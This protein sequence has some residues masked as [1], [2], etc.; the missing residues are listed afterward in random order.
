MPYG[1]I[2]AKPLGH[3]EEPVIEPCY[4]RLKPTEE[5]YV[6]PHHARANF[7]RIQE[8]TGNDWMP[9]SV[10]DFRGNPH[11]QGDTS[12]PT[13]CLKPL[14]DVMPQHRPDAV[15][16]TDS[17]VVKE[18][19]PVAS[20]DDGIYSTSKAFIGPIYKPPEEK[21][22]R[23]RRAQA[24]TLRSI[25][26]KGRRE[27][28]PKSNP[29]TTEI[30][31]ELFQ[32]YKE[33]EELEKE[34]DDL[35]SSCREPKLEP[36][37]EP[38]PVPDPKPIPEPEPVPS[39]VQLAPYYQNLS[40]DPL[41]SEEERKGCLS[42]AP[43]PPCG[44]L[45]YL[46][47]QPGQHP[48][49]GQVIPPFCDGSFPS[50]RPEWQPLPAFIVPHGP[51]PPPPPSFNYHLNLQRFPPPPNP[52]AHVFRA[53]DDCRPRNGGYVNSYPV[54]WNCPNWGQNSAHADCGENSRDVLP[55]RPEHPM[56]EGHGHDG[57]CETREG[58]RGDAPVDV[59]NGIDVRVNQQCQE[60]KLQKLQK[61]LI[62]LRGLPGSGKTTLSRILLGQSR[63]GIVF[64][65]DDYF[66]HQDGYR[67][68]VNQLGDAHD[69]NQSRAKQAMAQGRSP[70]I[71]DNTNTQAWEMKPYVEMAIGKGYRVEFHEPE[72]WW[73][74]DPEELE[75]RNKHGVSRKK[76]AQMLER[77]EYHVSISIVMNSA[78][79]SHRSA[80]RPP[81]PECRQR[82]G[83]L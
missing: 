23:E 35:E 77:Y 10:L 53:Q 56:C 44:Y 2:E 69:W 39:L 47:S 17:Q 3:G 8:K 55:C 46:G 26:G 52:A 67:Y 76:I 82:W 20:T 1:E 81:P 38:E 74:F 59:C 64:S 83:A 42:A 78:D 28:A 21:R 50:F 32:F 22:R 16:C 30:D 7:D 40:R 25:N 14:H 60:A 13:D 27:E 79:P 57:F 37:P 5:A 4:K 12:H 71:I 33:I 61:L 70:V 41:G 72:T 73:K 6:F 45:P 19:G 15:G 49:D 51:P 18:A 31:S 48:R 62:L 34:K 54:N 80:A 29:K 63:D 24:R 9:V 58:C 65:T 68:N 43:Q 36:E 11:P 66:R 75:K